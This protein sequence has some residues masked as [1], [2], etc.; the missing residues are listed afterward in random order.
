MQ[1]QACGR[2]TSV[3]AGTIFQDTRKPLVDWFR[4]MY[5]VASRKRAVVPWGAGVLFGLSHFINGVDV[6]AEIARKRWC[7]QP[8]SA[9]GGWSG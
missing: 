1:C 7:G 8:G 3:T 6:A 9:A 2:Q 4:A 5:W